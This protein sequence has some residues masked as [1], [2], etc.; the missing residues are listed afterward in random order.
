MNRPFYWLGVMLF[1][2]FISTG[3][4]GT[5][6]Y[7]LPDDSAPGRTTITGYTP[8]A[9]E[10]KPDDQ[11]T[12]DRLEDKPALPFD[13]ELV[14][15]RPFGQASINV[16]AALIKLHV[17][18]T[19]PRDEAPLLQ[20]HPSYAAAMAAARKLHRDETILPS[21]NLLDGKAK[22][23]DDGLYAALDLAYY[24]GLHDRLHGHVELVRRIYGRPTRRAKQPPSWRPAWSWQEC[25]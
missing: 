6:A 12:D 11:L 2:C 13:P 16:S 9:S 14:D 23:F 7:L 19:D 4:I 22:Q 18:P 8:I 5:L 15:R 24:H 20:L 21:V 3:C 17:P 10:E 1:G 25:M